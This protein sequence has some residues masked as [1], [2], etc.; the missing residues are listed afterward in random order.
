MR[1]DASSLR[2]FLTK[3]SRRVRGL[4]A[5]RGAS[6]GIIAGG[7]LIAANAA[8]E[9]WALRTAVAALLAILGAA[10]SAL[11][12]PAASWQIVR[13]V[14]RREARS[15]NLLLTATELLDARIAA[16]PHVADRVYRDAASLLPVVRLDHI[17]PAARDLALAA[18]ASMV[19]GVIVMVSSSAGAK[20]SE[21]G[22]SS[23]SAAII[24]GVSVEMVPPPYTGQPP[25]T[26]DNPSRLEVLAGTTLTLTTTADASRVV[27]E[28]L[29]GSRELEATRSGRF[30]M[31]F[32][33]EADGFVALAPFA[34]DG[35]AG[36]RRLIGLTVT[37]DRMPRVRV[38]MPGKD[39]FLPHGRQTISLSVE[40]DDDLEL[41]RLSVAYTR[42]AGSGETFTFSNGELPLE[43]ARTNPAAWTGRAT[44][45]IDALGLQPGDML[46][47][48][49][50]AADRRPNAPPAE[51]DNF[52]IEITAPGAL[53]SEG[54]AVDDR[55]DKYAISQQMV[56]VK[57]ERL[58]AQRAKL[59]AEAFREESLDL[60]A[61]QRQVRAEFVFM[62]GGELAEAGLDLSTLN[63]EVEA[64][65]E[66]D[67]A[68]GRLANQ[69]R[70]ELLRAIRSMSRAAARLADGDAAGALPHEKEALGFLQRAFSRSRYILR[71][72]GERERI[73]LSRRMTGLL[74]ALS[75]ESRP[76]S[77]AEGSTRVAAL[78]R[79]LAEVASLAAGLQ[80]E[81]DGG[82]A[83]STLLAQRLLEVDP[84]S[85]DLREAAS[86]LADAAALPAPGRG[87]ALSSA[88][89]RAATI[90]SA[91][92][93]RALPADPK[94]RAEPDLDVLSGAMADALR[95]PG[96]S[97]GRQGGS[98]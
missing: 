64:A 65:G 86:A 19:A 3:A 96:G 40:A 32:I 22:P 6:A 81:P 93:R 25:K 37:A 61:E 82:S 62:M 97:P 13:N 59:S 10:V 88:L 52:I 12:A 80:A 7:L 49:G 5:L 92:A 48:R 31:N 78:R 46:I 71:A 4:Y 24:T 28:T 89:D 14:E 47:Y 68:A 83:R 39:L 29:A 17:F 58:L 66:D 18:G 44:W 45:R 63:E 56:I 70:F 54:F 73:D 53:P 2:A 55:Q 43:I 79:V 57:T 8:G 67:L 33:A 87:T 94:W 27:S 16:A 50:V 95:K 74:A 42:I 51:S 69:G 9:S 75:R 23:P 91:L 77:A 26:I 72:L 35:T 30:I 76:A 41:E 98:Q 36:V 34:A 60:A 85:W 20:T 84:S 1:P 38:T 15:R 21:S 11:L 90:L